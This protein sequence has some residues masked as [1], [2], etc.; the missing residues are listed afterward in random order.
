[1]QC[2]L[3]FII[4]V[5][6]K[7]LNNQICLHNS[8]SPPYPEIEAGPPPPTPA[9]MVP[10]VSCTIPCVARPQEIEYSIHTQLS[11]YLSLNLK[12]GRLMVVF[13]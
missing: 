8:H 3:M 2:C 13:I 5:N 10:K 11:A 9:G 7:N 6:K 4:A 1:M 12:L